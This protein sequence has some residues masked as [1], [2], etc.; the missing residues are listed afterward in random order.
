VAAGP[1]STGGGPLHLAEV[2]GQWGFCGAFMH[3]SG[4]DL[5]AHVGGGGPLR[6]GSAAP[7]ATTGGVWVSGYRRWGGSYW[8]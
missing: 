4:G 7:V 2:G 3:I 6:A 1:F 8:L 5:G